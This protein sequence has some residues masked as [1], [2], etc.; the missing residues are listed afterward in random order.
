VSR[1][2]IS[3]A[4]SC[5]SFLFNWI[6]IWIRIRIQSS[7]LCMA[8]EVHL[9]SWELIVLLVCNNTCCTFFW[10]SCQAIY[11]VES[12]CYYVCNTCCVFFSCNYRTILQLFVS[13]FKL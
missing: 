7:V 3:Y 12:M 2:S 11:F 9:C 4:P 13:Y 6:W 8:H 1:F 5:I 10:C